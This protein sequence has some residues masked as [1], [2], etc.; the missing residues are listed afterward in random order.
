VVVAL[1]LIPVLADFL[2]PYVVTIA[3]VA[4]TGAIA[5]VG[6]VLW[7][8]ATA[9]APTLV[10]LDLRQNGADVMNEGDFT[11]HVHSLDRLDPARQIDLDEPNRVASGRDASYYFVPDTGPLR[12]DQS[13]RLVVSDD[14][15]ARW[16]LAY[17]PPH[18]VGAMRPVW[19]RRIWPLPVLW[20]L[21]RPP[22]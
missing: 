21:Q 7:R 11:V 10:R 16:E 22:S 15:R 3:G 20:L 6:R 17:K 4:T 8:W 1:V 18:R 19:A 5:L 14:H 13:Y 9:P 12:V 2:G